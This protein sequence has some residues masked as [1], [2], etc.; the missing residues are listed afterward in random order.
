MVDDLIIVPKLFKQDPQCSH[1]GERHWYPIQPTKASSLP[2]HCTRS[3]R[4]KWRVWDSP[5]A[6]KISAAS[7][8]WRA[9]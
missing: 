9:A 2:V 7:L 6:L 4:Q 3:A 1:P 8:L 5:V